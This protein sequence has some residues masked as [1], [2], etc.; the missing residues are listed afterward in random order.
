VT[1]IDGRGRLADR[2]PLQVLQ[3][4]SG[5]RVAVSVVSGAIVIV[6]QRDGAHAITRQG[7]LRLPVAVR[8]VCRLEAGNRL[9]LVACADRNLLMAYTMCA[10]EAMVFAYHAALSGETRQ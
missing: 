8:R 5:L 10:L 9:L 2:S 3:W 4:R 1:T 7:H 6:S